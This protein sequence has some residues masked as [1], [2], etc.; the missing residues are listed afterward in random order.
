[1]TRSALSRAAAAF[2]LTAALGVLATPAHAGPAA[3]PA[4]PAPAIAPVDDDISDPSRPV[5]IDVGRFEPRTITPGAEVTITGTVTNTGSAAVRDLAVRL[6]RGSVITTRAELAAERDDPDPATAVVPRFQ[7]IP[8]QLAPGQSLPFSYTLPSEELQLD[9]DGVY[10]ALINVNGIVEDEPQRVAELRTYLV[11]QPP[12]P[13]ARTTVA[14]LWPLVERTSRTPAGGFTDDHLTA[15]VAPGG[16][17]DRALEVLER[18]PSTTTDDGSAGRPELSPTVAVDPALVEAL[19][20]MARGPYPVAGVA[21]AG[22]GSDGAA[23][24]LERLRSVAAAHRVV[25]LPYG[26]VDA[27]S[28]VAAGLP[29]VLERSLPGTPT[30]TARASGPAPE[31]DATPAPVTPGPDGATPANGTADLGAGAALLVDVLG[32]TPRTDLAWTADGSL[33][34]S[35][36]DV[37]LGGGIRQLVLGSD[38]LTDGADAVGL[39][40]GTATAHTTVLAT[41]GPVDAL[42]ADRTL[43]DIAGTADRSPGGAR[44]AEQRYL[45]ELAVITQQAPDGSTPTVLVA[46]ERAVDPGPEGIGAMMAD[47]TALPWLVPGTLDGLGGAPSGPAGELS[48]P[49]VPLRLDPAGMRDVVTAVAARDDLAGA[50]VTDPATAL[51][52][53]D[54]AIARATSLAWRDEPAGF[55]SAAGDLIALFDRLRSQVALLAPADGTYTLASSDAPLVLTVRNDL[56]FAVQVL[57]DLRA[58]GSRG[59][60]ITDIGP[61]ILAPGE[62]TTLQVPTEVRQAGGFAVTATLTT[63]SHRP[64]GAPV[65]L[66]VTSTAYGSI[67]LIITIGAGT[68]LGLLFLRR[69]VNFLR[70]RRR[71]AAGTTPAPAQAQPPTRSPV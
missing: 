13:T 42:V 11:Q 18:L 27:D 31:P 21:G 28:L 7:D 59:L 40:G 37:L 57:L 70:R 22:R 1:M 69:L 34:P 49:A 6:Q 68:L 48:T 24:Y 19:A 47:T 8:G 9:G 33:L 60:S 38:G 5:R 29:A 54:A 71:R 26:D 36:I 66:Q 12:V 44:L 23:A 3:P 62:R 52:S 39:N 4:R 50:I 43:S 41:A 2:L 10:P 30:G 51:Q 15:S 20:L 55:R 14:W 58:R 25:A 56:P 17:L 67:T 46:P 63:P 53:Y 35:T 32:I 45:A 16:R 61:Q 65:D 64:L